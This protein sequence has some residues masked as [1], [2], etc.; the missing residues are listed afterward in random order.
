MTQDLKTGDVIAN[1]FELTPLIP[2]NNGTV[3]LDAGLVSVQGANYLATFI[4]M[5]SDFSA[6]LA[7][8]QF[9]SALALADPLAK[10]LQGLLS[11][12]GVHLALHDAFAQDREGGYWMAIRADQSQLAPWTLRVVHNQLRHADGNPLIGFD[13]MLFRLQVTEHGPDYHSLSSIQDPMQQACI[14]LKDMKDVKADGLYRAALV[15]AHDSPELTTADRI[16]VKRQLHDDF[17]GLKK[18][19]GYSGLLGG[20]YDLSDAMKRA[21]SVEMALKEGDASWE[22]LF[23]TDT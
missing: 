3:S 15:A 4:G 9:S 11:S 20:Q 7:V 22:M 16:R 13:Y 10:G 5:L 17:V 21:M 6:L 8:P 14:A 2:F 18:D 19:L 23:A 1:N 12:G